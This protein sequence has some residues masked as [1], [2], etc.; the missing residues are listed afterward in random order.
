MH[1][2]FVLNFL[3]MLVHALAWGSGAAG[4]VSTCSTVLQVTL[5][6]QHFFHPFIVYIKKPNGLFQGQTRH[7]VSNS[8]MLLSAFLEVLETGS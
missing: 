1:A 8:S 3:R 2:F 4:L 7:H 5:H 6:L